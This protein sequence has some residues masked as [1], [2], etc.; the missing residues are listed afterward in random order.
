MR[1]GR[2]F[3]Q[4]DHALCIGKPVWWAFGPFPRVSV[5]WGTSLCTSLECKPSSLAGAAL[6]I[7]KHT[8]PSSPLNSFG[9]LTR[10][11]NQYHRSCIWHVQD[12]EFGQAKTKCHKKRSQRSTRRISV[13]RIERRTVVSPCESFLC[14]GRPVWLAFGHFSHV[15]VYWGNFLCTSLE[16]KAISLA[17]SARSNFGNTRLP[18][19]L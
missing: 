2:W 12:G 17:G 4:W 14:T 1:V 16:A 18:R 11:T 10:G 13:T 19:V 5:H 6:G 8:S 9:L 7:Q 15:S 3:P